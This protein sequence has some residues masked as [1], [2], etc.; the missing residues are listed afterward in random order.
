[1]CAVGGPGPY[2]EAPSA[3]AAGSAITWSPGEGVRRC[4]ECVVEGSGGGP[5]P[6][7]MKICGFV[8]LEEACPGLSA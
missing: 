7:C 1:M 4:K 8:H 5:G 6:L 3:A 2:R